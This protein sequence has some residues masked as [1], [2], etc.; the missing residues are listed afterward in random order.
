MESKYIERLGSNLPNF[1]ENLIWISKIVPLL[2][3]SSLGEKLS[4]IW[5]GLREGKKEGER[6][7]RGLIERQKTPADLF[8]NQE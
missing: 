6:D 5:A 8:E 4:E 2:N 7:G 3:D 1:K